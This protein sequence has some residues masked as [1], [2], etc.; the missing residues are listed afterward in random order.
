MLL[1]ALASRPA[2]HLRVAV[3]APSLSLLVQAVPPETCQSVQ[4]LVRLPSLE[5]LSVSH[6]GVLYP[7]AGLLG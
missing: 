2:L 5:L 3:L 7:L 4:M 1:A 6:Q